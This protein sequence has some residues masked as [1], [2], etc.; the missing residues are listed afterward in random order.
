MQNTNIIFKFLRCRRFNNHGHDGM[1]VVIISI[2]T[3]NAK[4]YK[5][6][7]IPR[8]SDNIAIYKC[9]VF[10]DCRTEILGYDFSV[11]LVLFYFAFVLTLY[12]KCPSALVIII[13]SV[14][15]LHRSAENIKSSSVM[16]GA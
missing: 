7:L 1:V 3:N 9:I 2:Y 15:L 11:A 6:F 13:G 4:H 14:Y 10:I 12:K 16:D 8:L 5:T